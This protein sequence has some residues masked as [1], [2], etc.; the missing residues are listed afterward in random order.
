MDRGSTK[1][2]SKRIS[3]INENLSEKDCG[4][5]LMNPNASENDTSP[6]PRRSNSLLSADSRE[7]IA[8]GKG[9]KPRSKSPSFF[10]MLVGGLRKF[11]TQDDDASKAEPTSL[12]DNE[13]LVSVYR[14]R[15]PVYA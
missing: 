3:S 6:L 15:R 4:L 13:E 2:Q 9:V 11:S 5:L 14:F 12:S 10:K 1:P 7:R 8:A